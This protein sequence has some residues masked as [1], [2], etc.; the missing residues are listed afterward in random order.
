MMQASQRMLAEERGETPLAPSTPAAATTTA[1]VN[2]ALPA[3]ATRAVVGP[4]AATATLDEALGMLD[5]L[6]A[7]PA[8]AAAAPAPAAVAT[9]PAA[10]TAEPPGGAMDVFDALAQAY[11]SSG[12][13]DGG[14]GGVGGPTAKAD[15]A[16]LPAAPRFIVTGDAVAA[17]C[18]AYR[19]DAEARL[20]RVVTPYEQ[21]ARGD[22]IVASRVAAALRPAFD[23]L[24]SS[25]AT[26]GTAAPPPAAAAAATTAV[27]TAAASQSVPA[28]PVIPRLDAVV[29]SAEEEEAAEGIALR[30]RAGT[31]GTTAADAAI[32]VGGAVV[33]QPVA[34]TGSA[35]EAV[36]GLV[37]DQQTLTAVTSAQDANLRLIYQRAY[38]ITRQL[39]VDTC[40]ARQRLERTID[41]EV[42]AELDCRVHTCTSR[43]GLLHVLPPSPPRLSVSDALTTAAQ[44]PPRRHAVRCV[45]PPRCRVAQHAAGL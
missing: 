13:E 37:G 38:L 34:T 23:A 32:V 12:D 30:R 26:K 29:V 6:A 42:C 4:I 21:A 35:P 10:S 20:T 14:E 36:D 33:L 3:A 17:A 45:V 39:A 22:E 16:T 40:A 43:S 9:G 15:A 2:P 41:L 25:R 5:G 8:S 11:P 19:R 7:G 1:L 44:A 24:S 27:V 28:P 18:A 31:A